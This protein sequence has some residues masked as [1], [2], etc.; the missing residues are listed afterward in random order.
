M[1]RS[2]HL[3]PLSHDH[4]AGLHV[5]RRLQSG[6]EKRAPAEE[7]EAF[8]VH[9][10]DTY[11]V[12]HFRQ[13]EALLVPALERTEGSELAVQMMGEHRALRRITEAMRAGTSAEDALDR[14]A[15]VL[16]AHIRFEEREVFPYL[17]QHL[18]PAALQTIGAQLHAEHVDP[19]L[20][21]PVPFWEG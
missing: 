15:T 4:Y 21:W 13:E 12:E 19:D 14:F 3:E 16:Q 11:L 6:L 1:K 20:S 17:E 10:W 2:E 18:R 5:V 8:V 7:M 9:F